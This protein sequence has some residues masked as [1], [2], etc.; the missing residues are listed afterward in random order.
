MQ[1]VRKKVSWKFFIAAVFI[2]KYKTTISKIFSIDWSNCKEDET[3]H[4]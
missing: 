2:M 3:D 1:K 4:G